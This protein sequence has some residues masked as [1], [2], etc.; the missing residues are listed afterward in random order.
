MECSDSAKHHDKIRVLYR[1]FFI[2]ALFTVLALGQ[3]TPTLAPELVEAR[4][5]H[6]EARSPDELRVVQKN[7]ERFAAEAHQRQD[8]RGEHDALYI[9]GNVYAS[10]NLN[11]QAIAAFEQVVAFRRQTE[12]RF[13]LALAMHNLATRYWLVG[14]S[15]R[16]LPLFEEVLKIRNELKDEFGLALT[17]QGLA[18]V[19]SALGEYAEALQG[20]RHS[21]QLWEKLGQKQGMADLRNSIGLVHVLLGDTARAEAELKASVAQ[22]R[23]IKNATGEAYALNNLALNA[24]SQGQYKKVLEINA[25]ILPVFEKT[26]NVG[27][28][29]YAIHNSGNAHAGL[30]DYSQAIALFERSRQLKLSLPDP[31][32]AAYSIHAQ[33]EAEWAMGHPAKARALFNEALEIRRG[34]ADRAGI[35][36]TLAG[37]ARLERA[38]HN[39]VTARERMAEAIPLIESLRQKLVSEDL[40]ASYFATQ[41][42]YYDFYVELL[43]ESHE[44]ALALEVAEQA[45]G[46]RLLDRF[47]ET[48]QDLNQSLDPAL[49]SEQK[50]LQRRINALAARLH[51][52]GERSNLQSQFESLL[53]QERDLRENIRRSNPLYSNLVTPAPIRVAGMQALLAPG[54]LLLHYFQGRDKSYV[55]A[56]EPKGLSAY[57][58]ASS[59]QTAEV[60]LGPVGK[61]LKRARRLIVSTD[62]LAESLPFAALSWEGA[63]LIARME[64]ASLPSLSALALHRARS[65]S[66]SVSAKQV[67]LVADPVYGV[68]DPRLPPNVQPDSGAFTRL[69][70][71]RDEAERISTLLPSAQ[72]TLLMDFEA[73]REN[74]LRQPLRSFGL[75]HLAAHTELNGQNPELS[76]IVLSRLDPQ[77]KPRDAFLRLSEI[78]SLD[79]QA[80]LVVLSACRSA[81][82]PR[83]RGEGLLGLTRGFLY[84][85]AATVLAT[86]SDVDDRA[87]S[88]LLARFYHGLL[89]EKLAPPAALRAAQNELRRNKAFADPRYWAPFALFGE[90]NGTWR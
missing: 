54:E 28:Q 10:L 37:S 26:N 87:T 11:R 65:Q 50:Q 27:A 60:L 84:A 75:I 35:I 17:Y 24:M 41:K 19:H 40:R 1:V 52:G 22:W 6:R 67:L 30:K 57:P 77:G 49:Q 85:G 29:A 58:L 88:L 68:P 3:T 64:L 13:Q 38:A 46:R 43:F 82:G 70:F 15:L 14:E 76:G 62:G 78:Y 86:L 59:Q 31:Y 72:R 9:L 47:N 45:R 8:F 32:G 63:P 74:F 42:D 2:A 66:P 55:W 25:T 44:P 69:R 18:N 53:R 39:L 51:Q 20:Y 73:S 21:L 34:I 48:L 90:W 4:K 12:D 5:Q 36:A 79:L 89:V 83:L 61:H 23:E 56:L 71:S 16:A 33:A 81:I 7:M 80:R